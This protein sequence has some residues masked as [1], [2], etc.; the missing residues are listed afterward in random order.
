MGGREGDRGRGER[1]KGGC[2]Q[3]PSIAGTE[4]I[5]EL[6]EARLEGLKQKS[7]RRKSRGA[8]EQRSRR[9]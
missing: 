3:G 7:R 5:E 1:E 6:L 9:A 4:E 8:G 2:I